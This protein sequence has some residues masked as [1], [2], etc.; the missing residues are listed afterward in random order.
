MLL[1]WSKD[2]MPTSP[3]DFLISE[4]MEIFRLSNS[5]CNDRENGLEYFMAALFSWYFNDFQYVKYTKSGAVFL[6]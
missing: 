5:F 4:S 2:F 6:C 3:K 1:G